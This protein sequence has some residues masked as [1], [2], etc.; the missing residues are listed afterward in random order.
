MRYQK[1]EDLGRPSLWNVA[2]QRWHDSV[3]GWGGGHV[4]ANGEKGQYG[5]QDGVLPS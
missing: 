4:G 1:E 5:L 2:F 3:T